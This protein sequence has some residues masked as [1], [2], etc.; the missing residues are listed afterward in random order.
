MTGFIKLHRSSLDSAVFS[1]ARTWQIWCWLLMQANWSKRQLLN[2]TVL[3]PGQLVIS[4]DRLSRDINCSKSTLFRVLRALQKCGNVHLKPERSGT[5]VT[6]VN[7]QTYQEWKKDDGTETERKPNVDE[8]PAETEEEGKNVIT[9]ETKGGFSFSWKDGELEF[10]SSLDNQTAREA[11]QDWIEYQRDKGRPVPR[12][13]AQLALERYAESGSATLARDIG[14]SISQN[15]NGIFPPGKAVVEQQ[16]AKQGPTK[17]E[18]WDRIRYRVMKCKRHDIEG[19]VCTVCQV[20][21]EYIVRATSQLK[22]EG[23]IA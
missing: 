2:G 1:N 14:Y 9:K 10:P 17:K 16:P 22:A 20:P 4:Y 23:V 15:W 18:A 6:I 13:S 5:V 8:T 21:A 11:M 7:W 3:N 12:K 19:G